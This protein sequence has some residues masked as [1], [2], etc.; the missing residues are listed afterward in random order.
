MT[1]QSSP[2]QKIIPYHVGFIIDGNRRWAKAKGLST[3]VGHKQGI[4][5]VKEI[6]KY[7]QELGVKV[8]TIYAF[9]TENW[10][11]SKKEVAYLMQ[12]FENF[13]ID[14]IKTA[15]E[16]GVQI[17][18]LGNSQELPKS[19]QNTLQTAVE[20]TK[21]NQ[22]IVVNIAINYGGRDEIVRAFRRLTTSGVKA[23][24]I[25][26]ELI[27]QNLDTAALPDPDFIIRTSGEQRLSNFLPWQA[28]YSELYFTQVYWPDFDKKQF[29][30]AILEF[31]KRQRRL[32]K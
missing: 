31:Q 12:L 21:N 5:R 27:S 3:F 25:T 20:S 10:R 8:V 23:E 7:A 18:V 13:A 17:K 19:L 28:I 9:S 30:L 16:N 14:Q 29:D 26:E 11:R 32:G 24:A 15:S 1:K 4:E 22:K 6:V 2:L